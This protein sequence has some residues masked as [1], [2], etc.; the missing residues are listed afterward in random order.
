MD[1][2]GSA[3]PTS[4][5]TDNSAE[6]STLDPLLSNGHLKGD[7]AISQTDCVSF[8]GENVSTHSS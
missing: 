1:S 7:A 6:P 5:T 3:E 8:S 2:T 4:Q